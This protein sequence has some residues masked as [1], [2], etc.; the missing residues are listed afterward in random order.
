MP[1]ESPLNMMH[2]QRGPQP[3]RGRSAVRPPRPWGIIITAAVIVVLAAGWCGLWYYAAGVANRTLNGWMAREAAAGRVYACGSQGIS[4]FPFR[5]QARC[6]EASAALNNL[7]PP[8]AAAAK[9]V[10]FTTQVFR[11][12]VL[13]G[14]V[15]GPLTVAAPGKPP[16]FVATWSAARISVSGLPPYPDAVSLQIV[17]PHLDAGATANAPI[18][19]AADDAN[20]QARVVAGSPDDHP[21]ID[22]VVHFSSATA[23]AMHPALAEPLQGDIELVLRGLKD[24]SPKP[25]AQRMQELQSAGGSIEIETLRLQ[26]ADATVVGSG[27]LTVN[28]HGKLDGVI[29]I[30]VDGLDTIVPQLGIDKLIGQGIDRLTGANGGSAQ[31]LSALDR[32]LPGLSG[33]VTAGANAS[34][35]DDLKKMG[36]P[37]EIDGKPATALPLRFADG[38]VYLGI[39]RIGEVPALF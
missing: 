35:I 18:W 13:V 10:T 26:R 1:G 22:A 14:D 3:R 36:Q 9:E 6:V 7:Q 20:F 31:G 15:T 17:Q 23:P 5:I 37:T 27:T 11:P 21:V 32:L 30:A 39:I 38:S 12:T 33:V 25:F 19:F 2:A 34:V 16:S 24:L 8:L 28:A 29:Q 4:G